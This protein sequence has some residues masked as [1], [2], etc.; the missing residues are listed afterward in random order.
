MLFD[1]SC[2]LT[3]VIGGQPHERILKKC[4]RDLACRPPNLIIGRNQLE[5]DVEVEEDQFLG[6]DPKACVG[7]LSL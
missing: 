4:L 7:K 6:L 3:E 5:S 1:V 2:S